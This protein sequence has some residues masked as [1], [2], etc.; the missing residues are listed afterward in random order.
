MDDY[1]A[2]CIRYGENYASR[3]FMCQV[4][5]SSEV[6]KCIPGDEDPVPWCIR[7]EVVVP[8]NM[9]IPGSCQYS[10]SNEPPSTG[11]PFQS[12][13]D[14]LC[15]SVLDAKNKFSPQAHSIELG[16][17]AT[18]WYMK[19]NPRSRVYRVLSHGSEKTTFMI[20]RTVW[21]IITE[22]AGQ[23]HR[24]GTLAFGFSDHS[25]KCSVVAQHH[26]NIS[27]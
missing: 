26:N 16:L 8:A 10:R 19:F 24:R 7:E 4:P 12:L 27:L 1:D 15:Q 25:V 23:R 14:A 5:H 6:A 13:P 18:R 20:Q 9:I 21:F 2:V 17:T 3:R 22:K 11:F